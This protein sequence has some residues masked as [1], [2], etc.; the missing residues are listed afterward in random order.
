M[1]M[2]PFVDRVLIYIK[3]SASSLSVA[4][5]RHSLYAWSLYFGSYLVRRP[6][7]CFLVAMMEAT[8]Y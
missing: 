6:P 5:R 4:P 7:G 2:L 1:L 3:E 8:F